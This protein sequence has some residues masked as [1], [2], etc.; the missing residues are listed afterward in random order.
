[1]KTLGK[2]CGVVAVLSLPAPA[3]GE[4]GRDTS[5]QWDTW[6]ISSSEHLASGRKYNS[7][8]LLNL[9]DGRAETAWVWSGDGKCYAKQPL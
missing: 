5:L 9:V 8:P 1:M 4:G 2:I 3:R 7:Y 6:R